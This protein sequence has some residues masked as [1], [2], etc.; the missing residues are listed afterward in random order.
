MKRS[1][2]FFTM[3]QFLLY[4]LLF[5]KGKDCDVK[6]AFIENISK[7]RHYI[8]NMINDS[9]ISHK[10]I[11]PTYHNLFK[12]EISADI[13]TKKYRILSSIGFIAKSIST[14][15][16]IRYVDLNKHQGFQ[17]IF[18]EDEKLFGIC[19]TA[20]K[21]KDFAIKYKARE[22]IIKYGREDYLARY[23]DEIK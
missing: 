18:I 9:L 17:S 8:L 22:I 2:K 1:I 13:K 5:G 11:I 14:V 21:D 4:P 20:F 23:S 16:N 3:V 10:E 12:E 19:I 6:D 15:N 7:N